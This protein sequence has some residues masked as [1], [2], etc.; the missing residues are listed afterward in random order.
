MRS[1]LLFALLAAC[2]TPVVQPLS[3]AKKLEPT[4]AVPKDSKTPVTAPEPPAATRPASPDPAAEIPFKRPGDAASQRDDLTFWGWS[5]DSARYAFEVRDHGPGATVC[6]GSYTLYIVDAARD[7]FAEGTPLKVE[8]KNKGDDDKCDPPDLGAEMEKQRPA[9]LERHGIV[10]TNQRAPILPS[11]VGSTTGTDKIPAWALQL[12]PDTLLRAELEVLHG[13]R[14]KAGEPGG[15]YRL[16]LKHGADEPKVLEPGQRRRPFVWNYD[17]DT[18][19]AFLAP[20]GRHLAIL[21]AM[22]QLSFEGDRHTYM[23][24]GVALPPAWVPGA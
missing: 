19:L 6:E 16:T 17:L 11:R 7:T 23:S 8:H 9:L 2:G 21:V 14:D 22:T 4:K 18:G 20:D 1:V 5:N 12:G 15:A 13:G 10:I 3:E 24:N